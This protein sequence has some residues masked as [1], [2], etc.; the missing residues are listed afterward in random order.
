MTKRISRRSFT[1]RMPSPLLLLAEPTPQLRNRSTA[2][3]K[4]IAARNV[5]DGDDG[6]LREAPL[7]QRGADRSI[8]ATAAATGYRR[9]RRHSAAGPYA[10]H[11]ES[12]PG[13]FPQ[14]A[15]AAHRRAAGKRIAMFHCG[16]DKRK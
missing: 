13:R 14:R 12:R 8:C 16:K 10:E 3:E 15:E 11:W 2:N 6:D 7:T 5:V 1:S 4:R 9:D